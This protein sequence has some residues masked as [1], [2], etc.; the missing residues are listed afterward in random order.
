MVH[1][2]GCGVVHDSEPELE[3]A[4]SAVK[5]RSMLTALAV[6]EGSG[7]LAPAMADGEAGQ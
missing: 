6:P 4:E 2:A 1:F 3:L 5:L 7:E